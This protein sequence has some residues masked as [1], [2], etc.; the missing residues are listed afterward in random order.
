MASN[1]E[2]QVINMYKESTATNDGN[3]SKNGNIALHGIHH[4]KKNKIL[5]KENTCN[6]I[7]SKC[8]YC[9]KHLKQNK[10]SITSVEENLETTLRNLDKNDQIKL[11]I[12]Y[13]HCTNEIS[14]KLT[15]CKKQL[16]KIICKLNSLCILN[17]KQKS[18]LPQATLQNFYFINKFMTSFDRNIHICHY[19]KTRILP[20]K[21]S[22]YDSYED[23]IIEE[24]A[25]FLSLY[26][27]YSDTIN[28]IFILK[29]N[30]NYNNR[31]KKI[32]Y[33]I[34]IKS[35][36]TT[37]CTNKYI[38]SSFEEITKNILS[39]IQSEYKLCFQPEKTFTNLK[40]ISLL[41]YD[42]HGYLYIEDGSVAQFVIELDGPQHFENIFNDLK[43]RQKYDCIKDYY[44]IIHNICLLRIELN[45]CKK[46]KLKLNE[47][48]KSFFN[49]IINKKNL[50]HQ[51]IGNSYLHNYKN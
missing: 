33:E 28:N 29:Q 11:C 16:A 12:Y 37:L 1:Y 10:S 7:S 32:L 24:E 26:K 4:L 15:P 17:P 49:L 40:C 34:L 44:C 35:P 50:V 5:C 21:L 41:R 14:L 13:I 47:I 20:L 31:T 48:I 9:F 6:Y 43:K 51:Y 39:C 45:Y 8:G 36:E 30:L 38:H 25:L 18:Y 23:K 46:E 27:L 19:N 3:L 2:K 22:D 42:F